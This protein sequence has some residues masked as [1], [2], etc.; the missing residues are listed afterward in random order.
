MQSFH[1]VGACALT[2]VLS[3]VVLSLV[4]LSAGSAFANDEPTKPDTEFEGHSAAVYDV[5]LSAD[6]K[7][8]ATASFDKTVKLWNV[9]TGAELTTLEG[10]ASKVYSVAF[11]VDGRMLVTGGED[12][13]VKLWQVPTDRAG[14]VAE[15]AARVGDFAISADGKLLV[16]AYADKTAKV[17]DRSSGKEVKRI[18]LGDSAARALAVDAG[19]KIV[20]VAC[21]DNAVRVWP[22]APPPAPEAE[23]AKSDAKG[24]AVAIA[25]PAD[26]W[27][28]L[29]GKAAPPKDWAALA[30][31][32][33]KWPEAPAGFG[34]SSAPA[35]LA[36]VKTRL[37]DMKSEKFVSVYVRKSFEVAD[38]ALVRKLVLKAVFDDG[39]VAYLN[40]EEVARANLNGN[41]PAFNAGASSA[42][43]PTSFEA[44]LTPHLGKLKKGKNVLAI[45]A[46]NASVT[47]SDFVFSPSVDA[48]I[49]KPVAPKKSVEPAK[50]P[51]APDL[52]IAGEKDLR[53][54]AFSPS[55]GLLAVA[56]EGSIVRVVSREDGKESGQL[57]QGG[58]ASSVI[59]IEEGRVAVG[60]ADGKIRLWNLGDGKLT[61]TIDA[62]TGS[63]RALDWHSGKKLLASC[64]EDGKARFWRIA[65]GAKALEV[66]DHEGAALAIGFSSDGSSFATGGA[67]KVLRVYNV[68]DGKK[69]AEFTNAEAVRAVAL[70]EDGKYY[71]AAQGSAVLDWRVPSV[72]AVHSMSGHGGLVHAVAFA[73]DGKSVASAGQDKTIRYWNVSDG[74]QIRSVNAH[75]STIYC[76]EFNHDG[77]VLASAGYDKVVKLWKTGDGSEMRKLEGHSDGVFAL[78]YSRD[79]AQLFSGSSDKTV[80]QWNVADGKQLSSLAEHRGW[81]TGLGLNADGTELHSVGYGGEILRSSVADGKIL[82]RRSVG[83]VVYSIAVSAD[84]KVLVTGNPRNRALLLR[85]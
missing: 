6:G 25:K 38:P 40:G 8:L 23:P 30:F 48:V 39:F 64:G 44:D 51:G 36:T 71:A 52:E 10:H 53:D 60:A 21:A 35:E 65:D 72:K 69:V 79:G 45:Q 34:Y 22:L 82:G 74:K 14:L 3:L 32:D 16:A 59:F 55:G 11:S 83:P 5:A 18:A 67:D 73:P 37:D 1:R 61:R 27:R 15:G 46:H 76:L 19:G 78:L 58:P 29:R 63:V 24:D 42:N 57:D 31:D 81:V 66:A 85:N 70:H 47:S 68:A 7:I 77:S 75:D 2:S 9:E 84:G 13:T 54:L 26:S 4:V 33:S 62:H 17:F 12:R 28:I 49:A 80:R 56:S 43:E 50:K 41:P 20:A